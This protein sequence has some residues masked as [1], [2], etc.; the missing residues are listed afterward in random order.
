MVDAQTVRRR[1]RKLDGLVQDL[2]ELADTS[3]EAFLEDARAQAAAERQ[4][5]VAIQLCLDV[6]AHVLSDRGVLDWD[7][8]REV[9]MRLADENV[10]SRELAERLARAAGQRNILVHL[11]LDVDPVL[12]HETLTNDLDAFV[13]FAERIDGLLDP[14]G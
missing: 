1:L 8:Y 6:G 12:V 10:L 7:E 13:A 2:R 4:L 9:P 14:P 5:Q 3:R 11:Y